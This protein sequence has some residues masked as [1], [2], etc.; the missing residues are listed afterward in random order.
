MLTAQENGLLCRV[1]GEAPMGGPPEQ[2]AAALKAEG[3]RI[4]EAA[5]RAKL[6]AK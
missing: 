2:L 1:E 5:R 4:A 3:E 6:Q